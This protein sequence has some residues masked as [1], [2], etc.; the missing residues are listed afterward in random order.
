MHN[1]HISYIRT[2]RSCRRKWDWSSGMR[3]NLEPAVPYAP[4]FIGRAVHYCLEMYYS[5]QVPIWDS[6]D[7][8]LENEEKIAGHLWQKEQEQWDD[9]VQLITEVLGHYAL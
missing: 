2:F 7:R 3:S 5:E 9:S 6:F 4:F 8:F 1:I